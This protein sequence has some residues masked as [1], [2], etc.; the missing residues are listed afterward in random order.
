MATRATIKGISY[1]A[2]SGAP[3]LTFF[4]FRR[5]SWRI[6]ALYTME[7][8]EE[9]AQKQKLKIGRGIGG[10]AFHGCFELC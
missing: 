7:W 3:S 5:T 6:A 10:T 1:E 8:A 4:L 2:S 9:T